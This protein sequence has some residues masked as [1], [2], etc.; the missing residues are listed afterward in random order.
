[1]FRPVGERKF[2]F[3]GSLSLHRQPVLSFLEARSL[4]C[5]TCPAFLV[6]LVFL[7]VGESSDSRVPYDVPIISEFVD[8][9]PD[10]L[11]SL[12]PHQ[13]VEFGID[14]ILSVTPISKAPYCLSPAELRELKK[15]L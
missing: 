6:C 2:S 14:L 3:R 1:M 15:Q 9:F 7:S 11:L 10:K 8:V 13:E 12:L 5:S 4:I